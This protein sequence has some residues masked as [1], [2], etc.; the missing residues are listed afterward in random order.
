MVIWNYLKQFGRDLASQKLRTAMT[1]F[2][3]VWGTVAVTLLLAFGEGLKRQMRRSWLGLGENIVICWP[4][5]TSRPWQ[6]LPR[7]RRIRVTDED[8][9]LV[10]REVPEISAISSE[11]RNS[12]SPLKVGRNVL[13]PQ[14][15][16]THPI[17][18]LMRNIIPA[19]GGRFIDPLDMRD[20]KRVLFLGDQLA[21]DLFGDGEPVGGYVRLAGV[22]FL[23]V[24]V[25]QTK[26]QDSSYSGSDEDKAWIPGDS[27]QTMFGARYIN[28]FVFQVADPKQVK[29]AT[30]KMV[31]VLARR[32]K[33]DPEDREAIMMWD[34]TEMMTF[35]EDFFVLFQTFLAVLGTLTLVVGGIG[36]SNIMNVVVEERTPEIGLKM[37]LGAKRR[38]V[39]GQFLFETFLITLAGGALGFAIGWGIC[40]VFPSLGL[41]EYVGDP[42]ISGRIAAGTVV[43]LGAISLIAG[44]FPA[45]IA[46]HL[47]PV[48]ALK[49]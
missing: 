44:W 15:V 16:G 26:S 32:H 24:G 5:Q 10:R 49:M 20:R 37:A 36:V 4:T 30:D 29:T 31:A 25:M 3:I 33:F 18:A 45:R 43:V 47:N 34:T 41:A 9:D 11:F 23:V 17:F 7:G 13:V 21:R 1:I 42:A 14:V 27:Y 35:L 19:E 22:P 8:I 28:N 40:A 38:Y 48:E 46:A 12:A 39:M 2:G 6:G